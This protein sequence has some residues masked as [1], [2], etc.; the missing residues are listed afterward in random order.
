MIIGNNKRE[1]INNIKIAADNKEFNK[2]V[3]VNDPKLSTEQKIKIIENYF[4]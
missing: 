4:Q 3:E 2:K 1:V